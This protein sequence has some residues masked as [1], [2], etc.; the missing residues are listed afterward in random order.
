VADLTKYDL[1]LSDLSSVESQAL[2]LR[3]KCKT[4]AQANEVLEEQISK[5][6]GENHELKEK[7]HKLESELEKSAEPVKDDDIFT[8]MNAGEREKLKLRLQNLLSKIEYHI[9]SSN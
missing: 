1:L 7:I 8:S 4:L 5:I 9:S 3:D 2:V 6:A